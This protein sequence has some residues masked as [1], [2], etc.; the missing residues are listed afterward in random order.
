MYLK[1][2]KI[3]SLANFSGRLINFLVGTFFIPFLVRYFSPAEMAVYASSLFSYT[4][5]F[6]AILNSFFELFL[7]PVLLKKNL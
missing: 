5:S 2:L 3:Q 1:D 4:M 7:F 6:G